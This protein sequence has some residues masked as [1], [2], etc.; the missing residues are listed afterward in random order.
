MLHITIIAITLLIYHNVQ[1]FVL[2]WNKY[3]FSYYVQKLHQCGIESQGRGP[4]FSSLGQAGRF[5]RKR[6][7]EK[8]K[9]STSFRI[10]YPISRQTPTAST[11]VVLQTR[12]LTPRY[13]LIFCDQYCDRRN[14]IMRGENC[15]HDIANKVHILKNK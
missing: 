5:S 9:G 4:F 15:L 2:S 10:P 8:I 1:G 11:V 14:T 7:G 12:E 6:E 13:T 3:Y